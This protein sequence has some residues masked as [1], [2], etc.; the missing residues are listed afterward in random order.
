MKNVTGLVCKECGRQQPI[1]PQHVCEFCFG[2]L[3]V[4]YDTEQIAAT[5]TREEISRGPLSMWRYEDFLPAPAERVDIGA[6]FTRLVEAPRLAA[7][8][9][10]KRL[11][12]KSDAPNPTHSFKDRV[13]SVALSMARHF[14]YSVAACASTGNLA[15]AVAAHAAAAGMD[16]VVFIPHDLE[17]G[18]IAATTVYGGEVVGVEG[19]YDDV[20]RLCAELTAIKPWA[21]V[22]VNVRPYY[23]EGSKTLA[24]EVA[25]QLGWRAP[26]A[27][28]VPIASGSLLTK[29]AKGFREFRDAGL[30]ESSDVK[31]CGAQA[32]GCSP[33]ATAFAEGAEDVRPVKPS[34]IAK[35]L[36]IGDPADGYYALKEVRSSGGA[37]ASVPEADVAAG[38]SLL[39]RTEGIFTETA[40]GVTVSALERLVADGSITASDETVIFITG[41][42][43]KTLE[44]LGPV[45]PTRTIKPNVDEV[46]RALGGV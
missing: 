25:E 34:T 30:I 21:F 38:I 8:L 42:G 46:N 31:I 4:S 39:A 32:Q 24:F 45:A 35:S 43:L 33:V 13:V 7:E 12:I 29:V 14:G 22:N 17:R 41:I 37:I 40:G 3:E 9:G 6:G 2:P 28:V 16:S 23:S 10:L 20:N 11:W 1:A 27:V 5:V 18:K 19:S 36:A 44:A 26:D 15:N